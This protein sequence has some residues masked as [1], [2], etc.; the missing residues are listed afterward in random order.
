MSKDAGTLAMPSNRRREFL[1]FRP[2]G[3]YPLAGGMEIRDPVDIQQRYPEYNERTCS[4]LNYLHWVSR[5][6]KDSDCTVQK[7]WEIRG[8]AELRM[9]A[10]RT[11]GTKSMDKG[12]YREAYDIFREGHRVYETLAA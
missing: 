7:P 5:G 3:A 2:R 12:E 10:A 8:P 1:N 9:R 6:R 4:L 11:R